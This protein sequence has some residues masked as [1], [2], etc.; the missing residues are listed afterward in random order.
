MKQAEREAEIEELGALLGTPER[1]RCVLHIDRATFE[2]WTEIKPRRRGE[3]VLLI[4]RRNGNCILHSK[5]FYP[6]GAVRL[7]SGGLKKGESLLDAANREAAEETGLEVVVERF[8]AV[9]D[10]EFHFNNQVIDFASYLFLLRETG[11]ELESHDMDER[12][13]GFSE[14]GLEDLR[15]VAECLEQV[16][17]EWRDWGCFR[18]YPHRLAAEL[19]C[20]SG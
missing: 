13:C 8:L 6:A 9:V 4:R 5:D 16:P 2:W 18:S 15:F 11:G 12:I 10:F 3:V 19:L 17:S 7:P 20:G 1:R 14:V